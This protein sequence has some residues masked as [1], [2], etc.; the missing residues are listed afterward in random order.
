MTK[1]AVLFK[2][3]MSWGEYW[4]GLRHSRQFYFYFIFWGWGRELKLWFCGMLTPISP[5]RTQPQPPGALAIW[6][7]PE[8]LLSTIL[9]FIHNR[10]VLHNWTYSHILRILWTQMCNI[11][12]AW[13]DQPCIKRWNMNQDLG[14]DVLIK[15]C[16]D[17]QRLN[18][19][20]PPLWA[21]ILSVL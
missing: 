19:D 1:P 20:N 16:H 15:E 6:H 17:H 5:C 3:Q 18:K 21:N 11:N 9:H 4:E 8:C 13:R 7:D 2:L 10:E 14:W 12:H